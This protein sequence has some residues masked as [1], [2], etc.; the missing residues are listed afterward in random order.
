[1]TNEIAQDIKFLEEQYAGISQVLQLSDPEKRKEFE[2]M[3][4]DEDQELLDTEEFQREVIVESDGARQSFKA[5]LDDFTRVLQEGEARRLILLLESM[6][7]E[8]A[9]EEEDEFGLMSDDEELPDKLSM[10]GDKMQK[11]TCCDKG[12]NIF[13]AF[14]ADGGK[15]CDCGPESGCKGEC[16]PG[17]KCDNPECK[18]DVSGKCTCEGPCTC[19]KGGRCTCVGE[20]TCG[21]RG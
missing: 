1:L 15:T 20:C 9:G 11:E 8:E 7:E 18:C 14:Q 12:V 19:G 4:L 6:M 13:A 17:N 16:K 21:K 3:L 5:M 10:E 2:E